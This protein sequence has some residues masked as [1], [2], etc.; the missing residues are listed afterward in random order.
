[1]VIYLAKL[2]C[3]LV[4]IYAPKAESKALMKKLQEMSVI[5]IDTASQDEETAVLPDGYYHTDTK[6]RANA[7]ERNAETAEDALKILNA[8]YPEKK[9]LAGLFGGARYLTPDEFYLKRPQIEEALSLANEVIEKDRLIAEQKAEIVRLNTTKE[10]MLPWA[11]LDLPLS[12]SGTAKTRA[13]IGTV[14]GI[15]TLDSLCEKIAEA[16]PELSL[17]TEIVNTGKDVTYIFA[18]CPKDQTERA[19]AVL[20]QLAF[21]RPVQITS[22]LPRDKIASKEERAAKCKEKIDECL[23]RIKEISEKR[24]DIENL[25]DYCR[26]R[27]ERYRAVG[28][29]GETE[30]TVLIKGY[31][32]ERDMP[33]LEKTLNKDFTVVIESEEANEELAPVVLKN[34]AFARPAETLVKMYSLPGPHD[35]DPTPVT[36]FFYYLFFG[37]MFSDAGYGLLMIIATTLV[38]KKLKPSPSMRQNMRL[39]QYCGISTFLWGLVY[40]SFFG[41]SIAVISERFFGHR[42]TLPALIDPMNGDAVMM[43]VLSIALGFVEII[44]GLCAKF[45]TCMKN[46][47]KAGAFFDAGLWITTLLGIAIMALGFVAVPVLKNVGIVMTLVSAV[48]LILT[49]G[50]DKKNPI[51]RLFSGVASLYDITSY[52]S[53]LLSFSRLMALGLTTSA[54]SAVFNMLSAM[55]GKT[56]GGFILLLIVFPLGHAINF[57]LNVLGA[58]VHTLRLQY[59][60]LF[61]KFYEGGGREF[62]AFSFKSKYTGLN[63]E[64]IKEEN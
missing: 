11:S 9:G 33:Y 7:Y 8:R 44:A 1:M 21:A 14:A 57:G 28:E 38:L 19:E 41:D 42:V 45:A 54:M 53:D 62:K 31:I 64:N 52:V 4:S 13:F 47:D 59:V 61:S 16:D 35:I 20:R 39:F 18:C 24:H 27:A 6:D 40:G 36:G 48:G 50:R 49:Q 12:F 10:Q 23:S 55:G 17:Y 5:D 51:M 56:I 25:A 26:S 15:Y 2:K 22:K 37:M 43:L 32:A 46:G 60:E 34:N 63:T 29:I 58:Y 30:H 3:R